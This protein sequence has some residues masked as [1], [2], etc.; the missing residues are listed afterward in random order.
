MVEGDG[1]RILSGFF[2]HFEAA[3]S[4]PQFCHKMLLFRLRGYCNTP[5][6][7]IIEYH[8]DI[9]SCLILGNLKF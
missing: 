7:W 6:H 2:C 4:R 3:L 1:G 5:A 9:K 8:N